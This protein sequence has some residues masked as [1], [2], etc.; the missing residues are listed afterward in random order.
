MK[1]ELAKTGDLSD[2]EYKDYEKKL[3]N[4]RFNYVYLNKRGRI[5][6]EQDV[7]QAAVDLTTV[8]KQKTQACP[9]KPV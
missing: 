4:Q 7:E 2:E 6:A 3:R 5:Q 1:A 9:H 8:K